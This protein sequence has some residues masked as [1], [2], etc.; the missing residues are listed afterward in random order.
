M[1]PIH[2]IEDESNNMAGT[3]IITDDTP[4][5]S[6]PVKLYEMDSNCKITLKII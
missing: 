2:I 4:D 6:G 3:F 1:T 5:S